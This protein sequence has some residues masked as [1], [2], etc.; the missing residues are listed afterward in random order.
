[1]A[2]RALARLLAVMA[3]LALVRGF[4]GVARPLASAP[5]VASRLQTVR[6]MSD[7][8]AEVA[9]VTGASRGIGKAIAVAL[10]KAG[11]KVVVN[12]ASSADA[13]NKVVDEIKA[14]GADAVAIQADVSKPEDVDA[15]FKATKDAFTEPVSILINNAGITK[16]GLVMTMKPEQWQG[17]IDLNLSGVFYCSKAAS[18]VMFRSRRGRIINIASVVGQIGNPGQANYAA[19]KG[20]VLG[21]TRA[22]AKEFAKRNICVNAVCPGFI[23]SDMTES[24]DLSGIKAAIP[25]GRLGTADEVA[26][27]VR[28]LAV[29][30]AAAYITGHSFTVDGGIAIG[31]T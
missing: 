24:L 25:L 27:L 30:P 21:L 1:M 13:A 3:P 16:D 17:V 5:R 19:A 14:L 4:I 23:E 12:Y 31:A 29:D 8:K 10:G 7:G 15:L 26:G 6:M 28:F 22:N 9:V 11:C 20:G 18:S 2:G